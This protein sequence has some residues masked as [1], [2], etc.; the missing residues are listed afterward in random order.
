M[1]K[2]IYLQEA[3]STIEA[4]YNL[5]QAGH[6]MHLYE[7]SVLTILKGE[8]NTIEIWGEL[9]PATE[10]HAKYI[11]EASAEYDKKCIVGS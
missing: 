8:L 2:S 1:S 5:I 11:M 7:N 4:L 9:S 6:I 10:M 3:E